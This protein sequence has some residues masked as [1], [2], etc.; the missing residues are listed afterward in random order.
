MSSSASESQESATERVFCEAPLS[1]FLLESLL[2]VGGGELED[3]GF[4]PVGEQIEQVAEVAPGLKA[5]K[6]AAGDERDEGGV[7]G[8]A[9]LGADKNPVFAPDRFLA[10]VSL[11]DV[12]GHR[13]SAVVEEALKGL[14]L[15]DGVTDGRGDGRI[16][17]HEVALG[18]A[19]VEEVLDN[20][21]RLLVAHRF[22]LLARLI[23]DGPLELEERRHVR[24]RDFCAV[25]V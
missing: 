1:F 19:P 16:V 15:I 22:L 9:V 11:G 23:R 10:Q 13:Q 8:G 2:E 4:R 5:M 6:L 14:P 12:V 7:G 17:E 21:T 3:S 18:L 24:E 20:G 25:G